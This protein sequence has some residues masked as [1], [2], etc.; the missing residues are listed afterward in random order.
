MKK[1]FRITQKFSGNQ[2]ELQRII[3]DFAIDLKQ[4]CKEMGIWR[5]A[6]YKILDMRYLGYRLLHS[7]IVLLLTNNS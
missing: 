7:L 2:E 1:N 5:S 3:Q 6:R 4:L